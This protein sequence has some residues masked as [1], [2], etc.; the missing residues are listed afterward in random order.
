M[1]FRKSARV[2]LRNE[3]DRDL[4][5]YT[6]V[7][8]ETLDAWP[9][10]T[11]Y[12]HVAWKRFAFQ[13][14]ADTDKQFF[15]IDGCGHLIG[16]AW[17]VCTAEP[18]FRDFHFIME[19]NNEFRIDGEGQ[20]RIDYLGTEDSFGFSWGFRDVFT[21]PYIGINYLDRGSPGMLSIYRFLGSNPIRFNRSLDLRIDWTNEFR[22]W[23]PKAYAEFLAT[24]RDANERGGAYVDY[25]TT[26]Y[27]YQSAPGFPHDPLPPLAK[28]LI[29]VRGAN[30]A[31][32]Y[33]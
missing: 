8:F 25:A 28:R 1:P 14:N 26:Y 29:P 6:F 32:P 12:F 19:G 17:S 21:G 31:K 18:Y 16:R 3:T 4:H 24:I 27:W 9:E 2:T 20:P 11:G 5:N 23:A 7:E 13:L 10:D 30:E 22:T 33:R 15:H